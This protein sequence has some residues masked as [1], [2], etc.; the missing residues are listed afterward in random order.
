MLSKAYDAHRFHKHSEAFPVAR[1]EEAV[2]KELDSFPAEEHALTTF[3]CNHVYRCVTKSKYSHCH[4]VKHQ[5]LL[6]VATSPPPT[7]TSLIH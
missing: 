5:A 3:G 4:Q 1:L 2:A 7:G 6:S